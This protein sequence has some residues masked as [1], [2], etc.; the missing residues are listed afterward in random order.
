MASEMSCP[1]CGELSARIK[2]DTGEYFCHECDDHWWYDE[3]KWLRSYANNLEA[4]LRRFLNPEDMGFAVS[5][6]V[7]DTIRDILGQQRVEQARYEIG[8]AAPSTAATK[9]TTE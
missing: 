1:G 7:R 2:D 6:W 9:E 5:P 4:G 3:S 8:A